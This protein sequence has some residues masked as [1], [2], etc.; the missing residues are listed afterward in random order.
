MSAASDAVRRA[1]LRLGA[2]DTAADQLLLTAQRLRALA[3]RSGVEHA[4]ATDLDSGYAAGPIAGTADDVDVDVLLDQPRPDRRYILVHTHRSNAGFSDLDA[5]VLVANRAVHAIGVV[6]HDGTWYLLA[7]G[8]RFTPVDPA[9]VAR[10]VRAVVVAARR[11]YLP[12]VASGSISPDVAKR[13]I[14]HDTWRF[15]APRLGL[16]Y[17]RVTPRKD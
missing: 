17:D 12:R 16:E 4:A 6:G 5:S 15:L 1:L 8:E 2:T 11:P 3:Q 7:K 9:V 13:R 14:L 10:L